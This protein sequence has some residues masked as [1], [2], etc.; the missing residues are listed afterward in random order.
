MDNKMIRVWRFQDAPADLQKLSPHGGDEDWL[1]VIPPGVF[2]D[3]GWVGWC[4]PGM[5]GAF[6]CCDI[7]EHTLPNGDIVRIGAH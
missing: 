5:L 3:G 6:G 2:L 1:A 7:S 4:D